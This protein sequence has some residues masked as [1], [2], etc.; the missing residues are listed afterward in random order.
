MLL[1]SGG[2][3]KR[4]QF[5]K[6]NITACLLDTCSKGAISIA[7]GVAERETITWPETVL[8]INSLVRCW[9]GAKLRRKLPHFQRAAK[10]FSLR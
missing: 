4:N 8:E 3:S 10:T 9:N 1:S 7:W 2:P 6:F 5:G